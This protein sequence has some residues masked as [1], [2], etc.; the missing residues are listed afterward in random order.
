M[1]EIGGLLKCRC[2]TENK[3]DVKVGRGCLTY[4]SILSIP[5]QFLSRVLKKSVLYNALVGSKQHR[6]SH[7]HLLHCFTLAQKGKTRLLD[8][9]FVVTYTSWQ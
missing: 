2:N 4:K 7:I 9:S 3:C 8:Y 5:S 6:Y 1:F